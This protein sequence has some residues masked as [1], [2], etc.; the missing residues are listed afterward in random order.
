MGLRKFCTVP[1]VIWFGLDRHALF[2]C[3]IISVYLR[4]QEFLA[5]FFQRGDV[6]SAGRIRTVIHVL[7]RHILDELFP[8]FDQQRHQL[9]LL[10]LLQVLFGIQ[11][12]HLASDLRF[13]QL[14]EDMLSLNNMRF[15]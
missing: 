9:E 3:T 12:R 15:S 7:R 2:Y 4:N 13:A 10:R 6:V 14:K 1:G 8:R 11:L 5:C